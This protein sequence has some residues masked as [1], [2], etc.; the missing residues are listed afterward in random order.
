MK[1][2]KEEYSKLKSEEQTGEGNSQFGTMWITN[3]SLEDNKKI[4]SN[5]EIPEGWKKGNCNYKLLRKNKN[6]YKELYETFIN[7]YDASSYEEFR[8]KYSTP[9]NFQNFRKNCKKYYKP[10]EIYRMANDITYN[11]HTFNEYEKSMKEK[12]TEYYKIYKDHTYKEFCEITG[13]NLD[14]GDFSRFI[15]KYVDGYKKKNVNP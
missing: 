13:T 5:N 4:N 12:Y 11:I 10:L 14:H 8:E 1:K 3:E 7:E 2:Y 6:E 9:K 15:Q